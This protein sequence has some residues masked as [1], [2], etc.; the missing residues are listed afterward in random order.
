MRET[1]TQAN[2]VA[3]RRDASPEA[4]GI[5]RS[6]PP[7]PPP[8]AQSRRRDARKA[9]ESRALLRPLALVCCVRLR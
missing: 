2:G 9:F 7:P 6:P 4:L 3:A 8:L 1:N 5:A